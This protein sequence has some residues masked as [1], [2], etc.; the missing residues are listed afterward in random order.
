MDEPGNSDLHE[1][2]A[3][4]LTAHT[5]PFNEASTWHGVLPRL[6]DGDQ[7]ATQI[8]Q[9]RIQ[10]TI[11]TDADGEFRI[12]VPGDPFQHPFPIIDHTMCQRL[13]NSWIEDPQSTAPGVG[14]GSPGYYSFTAR[15]GDQTTPT[16]PSAF[17][18][19]TPGPGGSFG[20]IVNRQ[21][22]SSGSLPYSLTQYGGHA[23]QFNNLLVSPANAYAKYYTS[24]ID[25]L[26][27]L[28]ANNSAYRVIGQ[29]TRVWSLQ[30]ELQPQTGI[31]RGAT[32]DSN[33]WLQN[34][35]TRSPFKVQDTVA[36][37]A[38]TNLPNYSIKA[39]NIWTNV[40]PA[41]C[42]P[43]AT[44]Q[45]QLT[46]W[47]VNCESQY[48]GLLYAMTQDIAN[49][50]TGDPFGSNA[51]VPVVAQTQS[52]K[53][54]LKQVA[55]ASEHAFS[56]KIFDGRKGISGRSAYSSAECP[57][58]KVMKPKSLMYPNG[59]ISGESSTTQVGLSDN[60]SV[61]TMPIQQYNTYSGSTPL[62]TL[63]YGN[64]LPYQTFISYD[65]PSNV[66]TIGDI[67]PI[68]PVA[69]FQ[70]GYPPAHT[71]EAYYSGVTQ[72]V[73][74]GGLGDITAKAPDMKKTSETQIDGYHFAGSQFQPLTQMYFEHVLTV[75][76]IPIQQ[77]TGVM[78]VEA[79]LD[80]NFASVLQ[81][82]QHREAFPRIVAGHSFWGHFKHAISRAGQAQ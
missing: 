6:P 59:Y 2:S 54:Y 74:I 4:W 66:Y 31:I 75:E 58:F 30:G 14:Q 68:N 25:Q 19:L 53:Q 81:M 9:I 69:Q 17:Q 55:E 15:D 79:P 63:P 65:S 5:A 22:P 21:P 27:S 8:Q 51:G 16:F 3:V 82:A 13:A 44:E 45:G 56:Y 60:R 72:T 1:N 10:S 71:G 39:S 70:P 11:M 36:L 49:N 18:I 32:L 12:I 61:V 46:K 47:N 24:Y 77:Q 38:F 64:T 33:M 20:G 78:N 42:S 37:A 23:L 57:S 41:L 76:V 62:T 29:G 48:G 26:M 50:R 35:D 7:K 52:W 28:V 34:T 67:G 73:Q 80:Q 40:C 43:L